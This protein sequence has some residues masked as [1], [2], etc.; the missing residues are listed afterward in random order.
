MFAPYGT[1]RFTVTSATVVG[2]AATVDK[3]ATSVATGNVDTGL[4][5]IVGAAGAGVACVEVVGGR[6]GGATDVPDDASVDPDTEVPSSHAVKTISVAATTARTR[7]PATTTHCPHHNPASNPPHIASARLPVSERRGV[8]VRGR[9][10]GVFDRR[11]SG[12]D[13][14]DQTGAIEVAS[15]V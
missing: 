1:T 8:R 12:D 14:L 3:G 7:E 4:D 6:S 9:I 11:K 13:R 15:G 2:D 10:W 5:A